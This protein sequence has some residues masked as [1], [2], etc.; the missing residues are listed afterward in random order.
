VRDTTVF[1]RERDR[2]L[3]GPGPKRLLTLDGG[4]VR[5]AITVA[6]LER[7]EAILSQRLGKPVPLGDWFDLIGGTSTGA[8][9]SGALAMGYSIEDVKRFYLELAPR[10]FKR[11]FWRIL[12]L[13]AKF[14]ARALRQ[15]IEAIVGDCTLDTEK[16]ITGL[17]VVTKRMDTGSPWIIANNPR[18]PYWQASPGNPATG[19]KGFT[20]N[21]DYK[22]ANLVRASTAAPFYFDPEWLP[23]ADGEPPGLF[24]DGG[25]TPHN[26]PSL[27]LF[28]MTILK[29][30]DLCWETGP[31]KLTVV[32][33]GTGSHRAR[34]VPDELGMGRTAKLAIHALTSLMNDIQTFVLT[35]MQYLGESPAPWPI[36]SEIGTMAGDGPP[37]GKMF[38]FIR[39]DVRLELPWIEKELGPEVEAAF[40]R[41]L[42]ELDVVRMRS[43]DDP[44]IIPD[45]YK[46]GTLAA[47]KQVKEEHWLGTLPDWCDQAPVTPRP[48]LP[49]KIETEPTPPSSSLGTAL[50][51]LRARLAQ[52]RNPSSKS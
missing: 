33:I 38:R 2:H 40:G 23:I 35:Q 21:K 12:G 24:V 22:L 37:N 18:A 52:M 36:N 8:I 19:E 26:S 27:V 20:G 46:L 16:L 43:M 4:G 49:S 39:Y 10:V 11:P 17:A 14:D 15:E 6:F 48:R 28:L 42:T 9:I 7:I 51:Y 29:A 13:Q 41:K 5:G 1:E 50:S 25:V 30:Y 31:D 47:K 44:T 45:I 34:V 3:F 32:S